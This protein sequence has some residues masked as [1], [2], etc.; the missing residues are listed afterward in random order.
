MARI[1]RKFGGDKP[2]YFEDPIVNR[3]CLGIPA[4]ESEIRRGYFM[5]LCDLVGLNGWD[6]NMT[7]DM[8]NGHMTYF[9]LANALHSTDFIP[10]IPND[11]NRAA[12]GMQLRKNYAL[13]SSAFKDYSCIERPFCSF[14]EMFIALA[15]NIDLDIMGSPD[16]NLDRSS[17]WFWVMMH[18]LGFNEFT[19]ARWDGKAGLF[20]EKTLDNLNKRRIGEDGSGG[21]FP[22]KRPQNDQRTTEIWYQMNAFFIENYDEL[23]LI[24][25]KF[26]NPPRDFEV[27]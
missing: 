19:D 18:N 26:G 27:F 5:Y 25:R 22:L 14:L 24:G 1:S 12:W 9:L 3:G 20:V 21:I 16:D 10:I 4:T 15:I 23:D 13:Y 2:E 11:D 7:L 8:K 17:D 6:N